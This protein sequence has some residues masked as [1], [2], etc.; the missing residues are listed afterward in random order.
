MEKTHKLRLCWLAC[1][2]L[3]A[4]M[5]GEAT[6]NVA[7][8]LTDYHGVS[9][10]RLSGWQSKYLADLGLRINVCYTCNRAA[11]PASLP[12][13]PPF[14]SRDRS[15]QAAVPVPPGVLPLCPSQL[16]NS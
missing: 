1:N 8:F 3:M 11:H 12:Y 4:S 5:F 6:A 10:L 15:C 9:V 14:T 2:L 7:K 16:I 13:F